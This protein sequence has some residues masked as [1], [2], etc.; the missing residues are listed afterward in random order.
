MDTIAAINSYLFDYLNDDVTLTGTLGNPGVS[1]GLASRADDYPYIVFAMNPTVNP[2]TPIIVSCD[3]QID[4]WDKPDSGLTTRI[5]EIRSQL[6]KLL[7]LHTFALDGDEAKAIRIYADSMGFVL[8]DPDDEFVQ[9]MITTWS[10]RF[11]RNSDLV[12]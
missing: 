1:E 12:Y 3:L 6:I 9:H 2:D 5:F 7:D 4:I 11:I 10:L 8:K